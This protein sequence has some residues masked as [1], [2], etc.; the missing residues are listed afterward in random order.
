[1]NDSSLYTGFSSADRLDLKDEMGSLRVL[2]K[3][4]YRDVKQTCD[5]QDL[6][7]QLKLRATPVGINYQ[8][9]AINIKFHKYLTIDGK[10]IERIFLEVDLITVRQRFGVRS[11]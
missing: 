10:M 11:I 3:K 4:K 9:S 7:N 8:V 6:F 2:V 1:M 5:I